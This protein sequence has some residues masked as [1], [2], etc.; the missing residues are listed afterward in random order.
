MVLFELL[1]L[2]QRYS[3]C[4]SVVSLLVYLVVIAKRDAFVIALSASCVLS[5]F[6]QYLDYT[7]M[8]MAE[9]EANIE[10]VRN[11]WYMSFALS[12]FMY[13]FVVYYI[14]DKLNLKQCKVTTFILTSYI[15]MGF[16]QLFRYADRILMETDLLGGVYQH[17]IP[18][19]NIAM[20]VAISY[21][22]V[23]NL[24]RLKLNKVNEL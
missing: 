5:I 17:M 22:V 14:T 1:D 20:L 9:S 6:H 12:D 10:F 19:I 13:V 16:I 3:L 15:V 23:S 7:L 11:A 8:K 24:V 4:I 2:I 21:F 18:T